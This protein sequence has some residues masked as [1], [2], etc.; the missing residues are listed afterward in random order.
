[1]FNHHNLRQYVA[2]NYQ[3]VRN[4]DQIRF[5]RDVCKEKNVLEL[6]Y[7]ERNFY[8][9]NDNDN[10]I[11][12]PVRSESGQEESEE[13][14]GRERIAAMKARAVAELQAH[15]VKAGTISPHRKNWRIAAARGETARRAWLIDVGNTAVTPAPRPPARGRS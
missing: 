7:D 12:K 4:Y 10:L 15:G 11:D 2:D 8:P 9:K 3:S 1:M 13:L 5:W 14:T 6:I